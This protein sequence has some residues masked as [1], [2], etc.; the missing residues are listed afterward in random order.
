MREDLENIIIAED[1]LNDQVTIL[2]SLEKVFGLAEPDK[3]TQ[4][5]NSILTSN[6]FPVPVLSGGDIRNT[7]KQLWH[8]FA[9]LKD[10]LKQRRELQQQCATFLARIRA[11]HVEVTRN[12]RPCLPVADFVDRI[13]LSSFPWR[14][15]N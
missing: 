4:T 14:S 2:D 6:M 11:A 1:V 12:S 15:K 8:V 3:V 7:K 10:L 5:A 13:K 9:F